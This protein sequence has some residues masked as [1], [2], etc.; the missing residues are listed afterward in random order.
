[1]AS[2]KCSPLSYILENYDIRPPLKQQSSCFFLI[3]HVTNVFLVL[4][5]ELSTLGCLSLSSFSGKYNICE[6][7]WKLLEELHSMGRLL[8]ALAII[9]LV[10]ISLP[11]ANVI[12]YFDQ[13]SLKKNKK[14]FVV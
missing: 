8:A 11:G 2:K 10:S 5:I 12:S 7:R 3:M 6:F 14:G 9:R 1:V 4:T 13:Q